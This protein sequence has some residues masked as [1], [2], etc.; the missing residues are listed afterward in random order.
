MR[1]H[2]AWQ[3]GWGPQGQQELWASDMFGFHPE[4]DMHWS[5]SEGPMP[6]VGVAGRGKNTW[7]TGVIKYA[8]SYSSGDHDWLDSGGHR[9]LQSDSVSVRP[10]VPAPL[11][12]PSS[13]E[14]ELLACGKDGCVALGRGGSGAFLPHG[15]AESKP[16]KLQNLMHMGQARSMTWGQQRLILH[17]S[18]GQM[19]SC[20]NSAPGGACQA[21]DLPP[22]HATLAVVTE[23]MKPHPMRLAIHKGQSSLVL[24]LSDVTARHP[25]P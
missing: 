5:E 3:K 19:A 6:H 9:R 24:E 14:P 7:Y 18:S 17:T 20:P 1:G 21:M 10:L 22:V 2:F 16:F 11:R 25:S 23:A 13:L 4:A 12:W 8:R 15:Y